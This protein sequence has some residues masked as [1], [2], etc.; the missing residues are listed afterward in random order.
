MNANTHNTHNATQSAQ[1]AEQR[2]F[3]FYTD[4]KDKAVITCP[5]C[6][7]SQSVNPQENRVLDI[8][9]LVNCLCGKSFKARI[10]YR[11]FSRKSVKLE[12]EYFNPSTGVA[13]GM[14]V[15]DLSLAGLG[16]LTD[17]RNS[18]IDGDVLDVQFT[19]DDGRDTTLQRRI[20]IKR[21]DGRHVGGE[22]TRTREYDPELALYL[23]S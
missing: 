5:H 14:M 19:L 1:H 3:S 9:F 8:P 16:F 6:R 22:F 20:R 10:E 21:V 13:G 4:R 15:H 2:I 23:R 7:F 17:E 11:L 12:G 18:I